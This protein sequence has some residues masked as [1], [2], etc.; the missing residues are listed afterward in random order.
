VVEEVV[1]HFSDRMLL[2]TGHIERDHLE[3]E[4]DGVA[5]TWS[6]SWPAQQAAIAKATG[7]PLSPISVV[8]R[9]RPAHIHGH[10]GG[11]YFGDWPMQIVTS[12]D[13]RRQAPILL[14]IVEAECH[15]R[16]FE[17]GGDWRLIPAY[18]SQVA[19]ATTT[20]RRPSVARSSAVRMRDVP[21]PTAATLEA[22]GS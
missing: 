6:L 7:R 3:S 21:I 16:I 9:L 1:A 19:D 22:D 4:E 8:A 14:A 10:L 18:S 11:S 17:T 5:V 15:Q 2:G 20:E 13:A 12:R